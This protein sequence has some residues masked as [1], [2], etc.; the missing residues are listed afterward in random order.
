MKKSLIAVF[1]IVLT[2]GTVA[3]ATLLIAPQTVYANDWNGDVPEWLSKAFD[4]ITSSATVSTAGSTLL[5]QIKGFTLDPLAHLLAQLVLKSLTASIVD[6]INTG[7]FG[8]PNFVQNI[9]QYML[10]I[11]DNQALNFVSEI[12]S[13]SNSP[14]ASIIASSLRTNYLQGS[15]VAGFWAANQCTL[16]KVSPNINSYLAGNFS[17]NGGWGAWFSLTTQPQNNPYSLYSRAQSELASRVGTVKAQQSQQLAANAGFLSWCNTPTVSS[18]GVSQ[19]SVS[20]GALGYTTSGNTS[21]VGGYSATKGA[22]N[23]G[24]SCVNQDGTTGTIATPGSIIHDDLSKALGSGVDSLVD[25]HDFDQMV[26]T[27]LSALA[28]KVLSS[29]LSALSSGGSGS[30]TSQ[31]AGS[32]SSTNPNAASINSNINGTVQG[33]LAQAA[34]YQSA[35]QTILAAAQT[36]SSSVAAV[37]A[38]EN[39]YAAGGDPYG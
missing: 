18:N 39:Y 16:S 30:F 27:I 29:G 1:A 36:A 32:S 5:T 4:A 31:L 37:F 25:T 6:W 24:D 13:Q 38:C 19:V 7:N 10:A 2:I 34:S 21:T 15:S 8:A 20:G 28:S 3:P 17:A 14:F 12:T 11:A 9:G 26:D 22:T 23:P 35:W 33:Q